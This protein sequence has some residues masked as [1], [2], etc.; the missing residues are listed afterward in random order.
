MSAHHGCNAHLRQRRLVRLLG[1]VQ[2]T[3][4]WQILRILWQGIRLLSGDNEKR[5]AIHDRMPES[6]G[7][8]R[9]RSKSHQ[10]TYR[11][12]FQAIM[13]EFQTYHP[14][15]HAFYNSKVIN[16]MLIV[17][18]TSILL[19]GYYNDM[20]LPLICA[21]LSFACAVAYS[22][23]FWIKKPREIIINPSLSQL[24]CLF[25]FYLIIIAPLQPDNIWWYM[26]P[27][28]VGIAVLFALLLRPSDQRFR[29][30]KQKQIF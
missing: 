13:T 17:C 2:R 30:T 12:V 19:T 6:V 16:A 24:S 23:W 7:H 18:V 10:L 22:I 21:S 1:L 4:S 11:Q 14:R 9:L 29:I 8:S 27:A 15:L 28:I 25:T 5:Q 3:R 20:L 26:L